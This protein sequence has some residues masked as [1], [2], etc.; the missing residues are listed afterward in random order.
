MTLLNK[1]SRD[2]TAREITHLSSESFSRNL[3]NY[4]TQLKRKK[5]LFFEGIR[6][7]S[8]AEVSCAK[9]LMRYVRGWSPVQGITYDIPIGHSKT[10]DFRV[11]GVLI[12][13]HPIILMRELH[14]PAYRMLQATLERGSQECKRGV[15]AALKTH[16]F[17]DYVDKRD[18]TIRIHHDPDIRDAELVVVGSAEDFYKEVLKRFATEPLPKLKEFLTRFKRGSF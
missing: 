2:P 10:C 18:F 9:A 5:H 1:R 16:L 11:A 17:L 4:R 15:R 8:Q 14:R 12:E 6:F 7:A 13:F 3:R